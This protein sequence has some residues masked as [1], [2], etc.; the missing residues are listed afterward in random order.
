MPARLPY[1]TIGHSTLSVDELAARL[2]AAKV[3]RLI[4]VRTIPRSR[5][6]PQFN[7]DVLPAALAP[8]GIAYEA[9]ASLGGRRSLQRNVAP[10]VN[11]FWDHRSFHNYAD[12]ALQPA[13]REGLAE[14]RAKGQ[15][16]RC[17]VMCSEAVWWRCHRR[18]V[19]DDFVARGWSVLHLLGP[20][21]TPAHV[22]NPDAVMVGDVLRYPGPQARLL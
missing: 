4:D 15:R 7:Q 13:L 1:F 5:T 14:L 11:G 2:K 17:A 6:N 22:L 8:H 18:L 12:Y 16:E 20:G 10:E 21:N 19:A 9:M 3:T